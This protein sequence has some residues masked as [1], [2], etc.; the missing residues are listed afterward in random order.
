MPVIGIV[1][2]YNPF[3]KGHLY[4]LNQARETIGASAVV[5]VMSGSFMQRGEPALLNK[6]AR[7]EM[8]LKSGADLVLELPVLYAARSAYWF[9]RGGVETLCSTGLVS[10][11]AFGV[12]AAK[13]ESLLNAA[14]ALAEESGAFKKALGSYLKEGMSYPRARALALNKE[15]DQSGSILSK[16][17]NILGISYLRVIREKNLPL[18]P[19]FIKRQGADYLEK[20]LNSS[21]YPSATAIRQKLQSNPPGTISLRD[22]FSEYL[23][24]SSLEIISREIALGR[25]PIFFKDLNQLLMALLRRTSKADIKGIVDV[26]EGLENRIKETAQIS[27]SIEEFLLALKT[28]RYTYTRLQRFLIHLLLNYTK[29]MEGCL[30]EG[31]PYIRVLGFSQRGKKLLAE[32]N[33]TASRP[34]FVKTAHIKKH[35]NVHKINT[36]WN[37]ETLATDLYSLLYSSGEEKKGGADYLTGP[38]MV[39]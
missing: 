30:E 18:V 3:H 4:H 23:P 21:Q 35:L 19:V 28:K 15:L 1:S 22:T 36:F 34:L 27:G 31:P 13:P 2:E 24:E 8:A 9:A 11:L 26:T 33:K 5:C 17:N 39:N 7:A 6:W 20:Q 32:I 29:E 16:P 25:G 10:H 14:K 37:A 38:V 12:E